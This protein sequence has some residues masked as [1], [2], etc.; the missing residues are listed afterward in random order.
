MKELKA[1]GVEVHFAAPAGK[2]SERAK[3]FAKV[4]IISAAQF[5]RSASEL[6]KIPSKFF[7]T[8]KELKKI[9]QKEEIS[10]LHATSLKAMAYLA[11]FPKITNT[12]W[13]HHDILKKKL[14]NDLW[15]RLF[16]ARCDL[17][18]VP[19][20]ASLEQFHRLGI[21]KAK[22]LHNGFLASDWKRRIFRETKKFRIGLVGEISKRKG[23]D[24][25]KNIFQ[26][27]VENCQDVEF[28]VIGEG[29]SEPEFAK[30]VKASISGLPVTFLGR[31]EDMKEQYAGLDVILVLSRQDPLPTVIIEAGFSGVPAVGTRVGGIPELIED[32]RSGFLVDSDVEVVQ[33]IEKLMNPQ[34]WNEMSEASFQK[35]KQEFSIEKLTEKLIQFYE[36]HSS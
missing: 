12:I 5:R 27:I 29:L 15:L 13:H 33:A 35:M 32:N 21:L 16:S 23:A 36:Y 18:L 34:K 24:R 8:Y 10:V 22:V 25:W 4:H 19:S 17:I 31:R 26:R 9:I 28:V 7:R 14:D 6:T 2:Y 1:K 20:K 11:F 3:E 30:N